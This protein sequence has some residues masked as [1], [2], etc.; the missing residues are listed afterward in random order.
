M[1]VAFTFL[2]S[3]LF[4][5]A[6]ATPDCYDFTVTKIDRNYLEMLPLMMY[7]NHVDWLTIQGNSNCAF[8]TY[9]D[10]FFQSYDPNVSGVYFKFIKGTSLSCTLDNTMYTYP[11]GTWLYSNS[12]LADPTICGY[13]VGVANSGTTT[14]MFEIIRT[15]AMFI[16]LS[17]FSVML[18]LSLQLM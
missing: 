6:A 11:N 18:I 3:A 7:Y 1:K 2:M 10:V 8:Y 5:H 12:I 14:G 16:S 9:E 17:L 4:Y 13:Y 15:N